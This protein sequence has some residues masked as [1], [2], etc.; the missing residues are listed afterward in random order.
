MKA[1]SMYETRRELYLYQIQHSLILIKGNL[2]KNSKLA[3]K[4]MNT[5]RELQLSRILRFSDD[6]IVVGSKQN[7]EYFFR[8]FF[9]PNYDFVLPEYQPFYIGGLKD[10]SE[11]AFYEHL[12]SYEAF[13]KITKVKEYINYDEYCINSLMDTDNVRYYEVQI[14]YPVLCIN[15]YFL[16]INFSQE[17]FFN[18]NVLRHLG[19][20][21]SGVILILDENS[22]ISDPNIEIY[23][24]LIYLFVDY[25]TVVIIN[26]YAELI[27]EQIKAINP[28]FR[29]SQIIN[30]EENYYW[31]RDVEKLITSDQRIHTSKRINQDSAV[32]EYMH[33][34][35]SNLYKDIS[36]ISKPKENTN[37]IENNSKI[38][39]EQF[40]EEKEYLLESIIKSLEDKFCALTNDPNIKEKIGE[41]FDGMP[42]EELLKK[43]GKIT[44]GKFLE[45]L[46][47]ESGKTVWEELNIILYYE[48]R[49]GMKERFNKNIEKRGYNKLDYEI[50]VKNEIVNEKDLFM[51]GVLFGDAETIG[52]EDIKQF[53]DSIRLL[54]YINTEIIR[55]FQ[56]NEI[57]EE[58][59][60]KEHYH[61]VRIDDYSKR[62]LTEYSFPEDILN[63]DSNIFSAFALIWGI[64]KNTNYEV[65]SIAKLADSL[66]H[67]KSN[68][69]NQYYIAMRKLSGEN[70]VLYPGINK[71]YLLKFISNKT[72]MAA[73]LTKYYFFETSEI[74]LNHIETSLN[75]LY[76]N[77]IKTFLDISEDS[78]YDDGNLLIRL[79]LPDL[80]S[81]INHI[82]FS[83]KRYYK[84]LKG[85]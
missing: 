67:Y 5:I 30:T 36:D 25:N 45:I 32:F 68:D 60:P 69:F 76:I 12:Y 55:I 49:K 6:T 41:V 8:Y 62:L 19:S 21:A 65:S 29:E 14:E 73:F 72:Y 34:K 15:K 44:I 77:L 28:H 51:L 85:V 4:V 48:V 1:F 70:E 53:S 74:M 31:K 64:N 27:T 50:D 80:Q 38:L 66:F 24:E 57:L 7:C 3:E 59:Y 79:L 10:E 39:L 42:F 78:S 17:R 82:E 47:R 18:E 43:D 2:P 11:P 56:S 63:S 58:T 23:K 54:P 61:Y 13:N 16:Y 37:N 9:Y 84:G 81:G 22:L 40:I 52:V 46:H 35:V 26:K 20:F 71:R 75:S 33:E 83:K